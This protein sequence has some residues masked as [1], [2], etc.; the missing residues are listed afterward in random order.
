MFCA[1]GKRQGCFFRILD[2]SMPHTTPNIFAS[3]RAFIEY[4]ASWLSGIGLVFL[5][6]GV[7]CQFASWGYCSV[8]LVPLFGGLGAFRPGFSTLALPMALLVVGLG[9]RVYSYY[10]WMFTLMLI[11]CFNTLFLSLAY[12]LWERLRLAQQSL[13]ITQQAGVS[14][15]QDISHYKES[16]FINL[17]FAILCTFAMIFLCLPSVRK[18]YWKDIPKS[19]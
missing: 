9:L 15:A 7:S 4:A 12:I 11:G 16:I 18:V 10:G 13:A 1:S 5:L 17:S 14:L 19:S 3:D 2:L 8:R 6:L